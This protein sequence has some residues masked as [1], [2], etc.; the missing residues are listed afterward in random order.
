MIKVLGYGSGNVK[1]IVNIYKRLNIPCEVVHEPK[2]LESATQLVLS[3]VGAFDQ[4]MGLLRRSGMMEQL[5]YLVME[6]RVPIIGVCVGMQMMASSSEEGTSE[7]LGWIK[8]RVKKMDTSKLQQRPALPH[9]G[10][11]TIEPRR[12]HPVFNDVDPEKGFYFLHS[13]CFHCDNSENE[14]AIS[15]Y[16]E[17]FSAAVYTD[18][19]YGFQFHPEK[20][21]FN[22]IAIFRN[23][24]GITSC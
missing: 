12:D 18:N 21:H 15:E 9:M 19:I 20:S 11:N 5:N 1:A 2:S 14:L 17:R 22:G 13:F 3:G 10:W 4:S 24:A 16:G 23:F 6:K 8:G 7:G